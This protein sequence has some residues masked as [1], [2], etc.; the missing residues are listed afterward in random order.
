MNK[1]RSLLI[2][3]TAPL[4][5]S[6]A[7]L[8]G[9]R[10]IVIPVE[11]LQAAL[12]WQFPFNNRYLELLDIQ[13]TNPRIVLQPET[14]RVLTSLDAAVTPP[15]LKRS[16]SGNLAISGQLQFDPARQALVLAQPR[17]ETFNV[18]GLDPLYANQLRL[19]GSL[20]AEQLLADVPLY[21]FRS[22]QLRYAG[23]RF[24][25]STIKA[26]PGGLVVTFEPAR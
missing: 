6:C 26:R 10:E 15:F 22:D 19:V 1:R 9:S 20:L 18:Q 25:P 24:V 21:T 5:V 3:A 2:L 4:F 12:E 23:T 8:L 13:L 14:N 17:I 11:R 7:T 16:W